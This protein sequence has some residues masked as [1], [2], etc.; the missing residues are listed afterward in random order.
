MKDQP[1]WTQVERPSLG[2]HAGVCG[3]SWENGP[4]AAPR[5]KHPYLS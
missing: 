2:V 1:R 4:A 5:L 3:A